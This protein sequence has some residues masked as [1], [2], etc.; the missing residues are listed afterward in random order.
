MTI[1]VSR[2]EI[3][4]QVIA[5]A[6]KVGQIAE[7][8]AV[9]ADKNA[10][11]SQNVIDAVI[12]GG[13]NRLIMP[14]EY[15]F[16][17]IDFTTFADMVKTVGYHNLSAAWVTYF[18]ALH[19]AWVAFLPKH[20]MDE[21]YN[22]GGLIADI[23]APVGSVEKVDGGFI[24]NGKWNFVSG[25]NYSEWISLGAMYRPA[26]GPPDRI[27]LCMRVS[28]LEVIVDW[29]SLGLRGSGSNTVIANAIFVP[30]D[31][32]ISFNEM[33]KNR[34]PYNLQI[35]EDYLY[36]NTS[37]SSAF[38]LGFG[39]MC[40]GAAE[41]VVDEFVS[42]TKKRVR[43]TGE[44]EGQSPKSQR[45]AA[46]LTVKL[47]AAKGLLR[48]YIDML[49]TDVGQYNDGEYN[50]MR[51]SLIKNCLEIAVRATS[52]LGASALAKGGIM[53]IM[54]RDLLTISTHV[55]SLYEDSIDQ[56]GK[57]IFGEATILFK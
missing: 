30:D 5:S 48:E 31:M 12:D 20:R 57:E 32:V 51:V 43:L 52:T 24:L 6:K 11:I 54:T 42:R 33:E 39:A 55:T 21:I 34:K 1:Q 23:F 27:G 8:E 9:E 37:F 49:E 41:R 2:E 50:A 13:L 15:G 22:D 10:T 46:E 14:K 18:Y 17:Q 45:V 56:Y 16:P 26:E 53:E 19:N 47:K 29:D 3:Y 35:S 36:F 25:I 38:Y 4:E 7:Q 44:N 28:E 40:I